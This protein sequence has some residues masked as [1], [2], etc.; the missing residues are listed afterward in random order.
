MTDTIAP[1]STPAAWTSFQPAALSSILKGWNGIVVERHHAAPGE[2]K[3][4][5]GPDAH[6]VM[7]LLGGA[8]GTIRDGV[9]STGKRLVSRGDVAF[10]PTGQAIA[11]RWDFHADTL[12]LRLD[13]AF[14]S[15]LAESSGADPRHIAFR[16]QRFAFDG[17]VRQFGLSL[18]GE[19]QSG[20]V[21]TRL[22]A[23]SLTAALAIHL[24]RRYSTLGERQADLPRTLSHSQLQQ[25]LEY[26]REK[27][28]CNLSV[29]E[30]TAVAGLSESTFTRLFK[31]ATGFAPHEYLI[32]YRV[33]RAAQ[34][35][36]RGERTVI[37]IAFA[38]GFADQSHLARHFRRIMG[39]S[40]AQFRKE[41]RNVL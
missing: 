20:G 26:I 28:N 40:P 29:A 1:I 2:T 15:R 18:L 19:L 17:E 3:V 41:N 25:A 16:R 31:Q 34:L 6:L 32:R 14:V 12:F 9:A 35:L 30:I 4:P 39:N 7:L 24:L 23:E 21:H 33:E 36:L 5:H 8:S 10:I 37:E 27:F 38:V 11:A 22:Y 13:P